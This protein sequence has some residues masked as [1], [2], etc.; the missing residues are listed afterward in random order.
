ME[1]LFCCPLCAAPLEREEHQYR[2]PNGHCFD[3]AAAG[4]TFKASGFSVR[5]D[6]FTVLYEE[7]RDDA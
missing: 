5:F 1:S 3:I 7:G 4:Y 2:C 6:G